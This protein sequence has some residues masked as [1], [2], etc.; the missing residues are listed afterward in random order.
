MKV[1]IHVV[2]WFEPKTYYLE[3]NKN[4]KTNPDAVIVKIYCS[5]DVYDRMREFIPGAS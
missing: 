5:P 3:F 1:P 2:R 4:P